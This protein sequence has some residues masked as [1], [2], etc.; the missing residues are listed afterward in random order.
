MRLSWAIYTH[1]HFGGIALNC[2]K[3]FYARPIGAMLICV[4]SWG[5][6]ARWRAKSG[7][8]ESIDA[9][10]VKEEGGNQAKEAKTGARG[11]S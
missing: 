2:Q 1:V 6:N 10:E 8:G 7:D 9:K 11:R 5:E 4:C 3:A